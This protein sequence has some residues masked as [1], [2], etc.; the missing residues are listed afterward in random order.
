MCHF[1]HILNFPAGLCGPIGNSS[2]ARFGPQAKVCASH[3]EPWSD[4][5]PYPVYTNSHQQTRL[6]IH[7]KSRHDPPRLRQMF[8]CLCNRADI[9]TLQMHCKL[10]NHKTTQSHH[11]LTKS[12]APSL[13]AT[14]FLRCSDT[15]GWEHP[16][17]TPL[18]GS[19][20][21]VDHVKCFPHLVWSLCKIWSLQLKTVS[22]KFRSMGPVLSLPYLTLPY[23]S[24]QAFY[25]LALRPPAGRMRI[26]VFNQSINI[27]LIKV[28]RRN[29]KQLKYWQC[30][31]SIK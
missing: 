29:L 19:G 6:P 2:L 15:V 13:A 24:G 31:H 20:N 14:V 17:G 25:R 30:I 9:C 27:R 5:K 21:M 10:L 4:V 8:K 18:Q 28:V 7:N 26:P 12:I 22:S 1:F 23:H 16:V 11:P 3:P